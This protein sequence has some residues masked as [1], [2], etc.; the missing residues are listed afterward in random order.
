MGRNGVQLEEGILNGS[1][2]VGPGLLCFGGVG[3]VRVCVR[4]L[5]LLRVSLRLIRDLRRVRT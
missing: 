1:S 4:P 5:Q 2:E 3:C